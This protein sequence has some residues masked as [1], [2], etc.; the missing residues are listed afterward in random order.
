[1]AVTARTLRLQRELAKELRKVT[2]QQVRD[3]VSAWVDAWDEVAPD[4]N[5]VLLDMLTSGGKVTKAQLLR[6]TR[7]QKALTVIADHLEGLARNAGVRITGDLRGVIATAGAAQASVID[8]QLPPGHDLVAMDSWSQVSDRA[9][10][11]IVRRSTQ[12]ITSRARP[13]APQAYD[14]VR[15]ELIRGVAAGSNPKTTAARMLQRAEGRFNGGLNRALVISRTETLD[16]HRAGAALGM[17]QHADVLRGWEWLAVL[18]ERTCP[19]CWAQHG[20]FHTLDDPGPNDHPQGRCARNPLTQSWGNLGF[21]I[22]EPP[23]VTPDA[24]TVFDSLTTEKQKAVL[25]PA[26]YEAYTAGHYPMGAWS[27]V[28]KNPEWRDSHVVTPVPA[29]YR[30]GRVSRRAA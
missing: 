30:G 29:D 15:R 10:D 3:L 14:A 16:A 27:M 22:P 25:G 28:K 26:R 5:T 18:D 8:S 2:D 21:D 7:L 9:I 20:S 19:S 12:Q 1:M 13:L 6:A 17:A 11:A 23:S 24:Q 4:L